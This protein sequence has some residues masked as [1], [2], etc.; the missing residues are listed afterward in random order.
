MPLI[1]QQNQVLAWLNDGEQAK[2]ILTQDLPELERKLA[3]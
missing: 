1:L 3:E 2:T